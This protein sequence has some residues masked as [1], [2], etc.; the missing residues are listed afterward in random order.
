MVYISRHRGF[1]N[2]D[3]HYSLVALK[4]REMLCK[5]RDNG[6]KW[7]KQWRPIHQSIEIGQRVTFRKVIV[8]H[9]V[10]NGKYNLF[11]KLFAFIRPVEYN[12]MVKRGVLWVI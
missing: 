4:N 6:A 8:G 2:Y 9:F 5:S 11:C 7:R 1:E 10:D 3:K 12:D